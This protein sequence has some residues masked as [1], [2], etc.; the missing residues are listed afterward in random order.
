MDSLTISSPTSKRSSAQDYSQLTLEDLFRDDDDFSLDFSNPLL[1]RDME[2]DVADTDTS[3]LPSPSSASSP[4]LKRLSRNF[5]RRFLA[6]PVAK[7]KPFTEEMIQLVKVLNDKP[8]RNMLI[9]KLLPIKA[10]YSVKLRFCSVVEEFEQTKERLERKFKGRKIISLF[11]Q[12][13]SMF[14]LAGI[15]KE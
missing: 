6:S 14:H 15:P 11:V 10:D 3:P 1:A 7:E 5:S 2:S 13:G 9:A 4:G 12:P 8:S